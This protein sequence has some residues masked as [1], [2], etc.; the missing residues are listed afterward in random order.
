[1]KDPEKRERELAQKRQAYAAN[2]DLFR[3]RVKEFRKKNPLYK[4]YCNIL[5]RCHNPNNK[6]Y[7]LYG[8]RGIEVCHEW[9]KSFATFKAWALANDW[10]RGLDIDRKDNDRDYSPDNCQCIPRKDNIR[11]QARVK[12]SVEKAAEIRR[13]LIEGV[14]G[15]EL[16]RMFDVSKQQISKIKRGTRWQ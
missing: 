11:K 16:A 12:L 7:Y 15:K 10:Q 1:M 4:V 8:A 13:L 9:R 3:K 6:K 14:K 5:E 2:P